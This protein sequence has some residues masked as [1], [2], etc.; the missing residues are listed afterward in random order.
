[1][2]ERISKTEL[3][4]SIADLI[5][6]RSTCCKL[7]VG[8]ILV[9]DDRIISTGYNG[10]PKGMLHC[11]NYWYSLFTNK[12]DDKLLNFEE[13][14]FEKNFEEETFENYLLS[15]EFRQKHHEWSLENEIHAETNA[16]MFASRNS[17]SSVDCD[18]YATHSPC[19]DCSKIIIAAGIKRVFYRELYKKG[20]KALS[21][22]SR[23]GIECHFISK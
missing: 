14:T 15:D 19:F 12:T 1:M 8:C 3:F 7:Q 11:Y 2:N 18:I 6:K 20:E 10:V 4:L 9:K 21:L 16:L 23:N 5:A 13:E 17:V 22:L